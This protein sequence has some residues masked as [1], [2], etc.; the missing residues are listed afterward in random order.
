MLKRGTRFGQWIATQSDDGDPKK[1]VKTM[2]S[3]LVV[4][5]VVAFALA[6]LPV[7]A[8]A[9]T[10]TTT[11]FGS[12]YTLTVTPTGTTNQFTVSLSIN[13]SGYSGPGTVISAVNVGLGAPVSS[14]SVIS[15]PAGTWTSSINGISSSNTGDSCIGSGTTFVCS[16]QSGPPFTSATVPNGTYT[17]SWTITLSQAADL[18]QNHIG[19][20]Y[21]NSTGTLEGNITSA[22]GTGVLVP[23]PGSL[24]LFGSGLVG[25]AAAIRRR[26]SG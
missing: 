17:W 2:R 13:T 18:S 3:M 21:N 7:V 26:A 10:F 22:T 4:A 15:T 25:I 23:E 11:D 16:Q 1:G 14:F 20:K 19:A 8:S 12:V 9:D 24:V 5:A 6:A